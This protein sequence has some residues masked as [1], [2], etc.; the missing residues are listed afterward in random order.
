MELALVLSPHLLFLF[1]PANK[2]CSLGVLFS[3][4]GLFDK[5]TQATCM[6]HSFSCA[7]LLLTID[8]FI[9]VRIRHQNKF[10]NV[11]WLIFSI[12]RYPQSAKILL[13]ILTLN[14]E[15]LMRGENQ[16]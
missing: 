13:D 3:I 1:L 15:F 10:D 4:A 8:N 16:D 6:H 14:Q 9:E 11:L 5:S 12:E 2:A 7:V